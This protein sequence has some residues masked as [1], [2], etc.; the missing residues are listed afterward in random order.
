LV[1]P[2]LHVVSNDIPLADA[3]WQLLEQEFTYRLVLELDELALLPSCLIGELALL[4]KRISTAGGLLR[5]CGLS[6]SNRDALRVS[7]LDARFSFHSTRDE[8]V[9]G[10]RPNKPR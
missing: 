9:M 2:P 3:I 5:I 7:K 4:Q 8:A 10:Y 6:D 1:D